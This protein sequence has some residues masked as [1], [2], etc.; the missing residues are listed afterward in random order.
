MKKETVNINIPLP[1]ATHRA[2][3]VSAA[4][5]GISLKV[6]VASAMVEKLERE[7]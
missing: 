3:K 5:T 4:K 6:W 1:D 2:A 7:K